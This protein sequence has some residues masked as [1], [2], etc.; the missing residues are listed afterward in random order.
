MI[1]ITAGADAFSCF[2]VA[3]PFIPGMRTS[4]KT[5]VG[6]ARCAWAK[7]SSPDQK[8]DLLYVSL[9][10]RHPVGNEK[11]LLSDVVRDRGDKA[12]ADVTHAL[13]TGSQFLFIQ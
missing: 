6:F 13:V 7:A 4:S 5:T 8:L 1:T 11:I 3:T 12:V 10:G 9:L 2:R